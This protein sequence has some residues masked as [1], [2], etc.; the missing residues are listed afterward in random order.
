MNKRILIVD[1]EEDI[2]KSLSRRYSLDEYDTATAE[3]G[4]EALKLLAQRKFHVVISDIKMPVMD[5]VD[6]LRRIRNEYPMT[7]VIMITGYVTLENALACLRHGADTCIF[8]PFE[9]MDELDAAVEN[10]LK[11]LEHWDQK[12]C[13]LR[14]MKP[15]T[16]RADG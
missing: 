11:Y 2:R 9:S 15:A 13:T 16:R 8:K 3:N 4:A 7:R 1:D 12:L 6:L 14:G 5:G 10:A